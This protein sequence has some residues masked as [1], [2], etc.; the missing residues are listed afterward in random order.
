M[1]PTNREKQ[2][3][4]F[5]KWK[6]RAETMCVKCVTEIERDEKPRTE[7]KGLI[8]KDMGKLSVEI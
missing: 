2:I 7:V 8:N 1:K 3:L 6:Y 4:N 5:R